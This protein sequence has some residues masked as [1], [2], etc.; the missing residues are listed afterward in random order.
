MTPE[1]MAEQILNRIGQTALTVNRRSER[2]LLVAIDGR[3]ASGKTTVAEA[4]RQIL[5]CPVIAMDDFFLRPEQR[6]AERL[7][8]PGENIDHE[9]FEDEILKPIYAGEA[10]VTYRP[11]S[12]RTQTFGEAKTFTTTGPVILIEGSYACHPA[13]RNAYDLR[14]FLT[15]D[16]KTQMERLQARD[17]SKVEAFKT[18]WI[19]LEE[20]YFAAC[21]VEND[22]D[23]VL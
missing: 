6:S 12:C 16:A 3:C 10:T 21:G 1:Q 13:L 17:A 2:P 4:L 14:V 15:V 18:R 22:C 23:L 20:S 19:P 11:F 9:R 8:Q 5:H 7:A